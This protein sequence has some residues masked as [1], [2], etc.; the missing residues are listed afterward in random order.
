MTAAERFVAALDFL[1]GDDEWTVRKK[2]WL[3]FRIGVLLRFSDTGRSISYLDNAEK[4]AE[5]ID[6]PILAVNS[7]FTR[8]FV[9]CMSGNMRPGLVEMEAS[10]AAAQQV[11]SGDLARSG[12][13]GTDPILEASPANEQV[14]FGI[15]RP[16]SQG[17]SLRS[18]ASSRK[19]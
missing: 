3:L 18:S 12:D 17:G 14:L 1:E 2:G 16:A 13:A 10:I 4:T 8:G 6:D 19:A 5:A 15:R 7:L 11:L 9:R